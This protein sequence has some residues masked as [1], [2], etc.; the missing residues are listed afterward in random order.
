MTQHVLEVVEF[1]LNN[2]VTTTAFLSEFQKTNVFLSSLPGFI[3]RH[4]GQNE[5]GL[6]IDIVEWT[7][8]KAAKDAGALSMTADA[9]QGF[10]SMINHETM[11]MRHF[12][13]KAAM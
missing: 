6:W 13:V 12:D 8:M 2:G 5:Q 3:K 9:V 4:L 7:T 11:H 1:K 10:F